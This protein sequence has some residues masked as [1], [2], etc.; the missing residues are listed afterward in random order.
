MKFLGKMRFMIILKVTK[1]Q[2]F[3]LYLEDTFFETPM[4][5][6]EIDP[7]TAVLGLTQQSMIIKIYSLRIKNI[8]LSSNKHKPGRFFLSFRNTS[9]LD[10]DKN[11]DAFT[12]QMFKYLSL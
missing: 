2:G 7:P 6:N 10:L 8:E 1:I 11:V 5:C 3:T 9:K 4:G 12:V